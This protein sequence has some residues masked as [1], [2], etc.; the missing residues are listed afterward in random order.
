MLH[1]SDSIW[2]QAPGCNRCS[3]Q[4]EKTAEAR[5]VVDIIFMFIAG[6][7]KDSKMIDWE[8][9]LLID[10]LETNKKWREAKEIMLQMWEEDPN[11]VKVCTRLAFLCWYTLQSGVY[12]GKTKL[13]YQVMMNA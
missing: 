2:H 8:W 10:E 1:K 4:A 9:A 12:H 3:E 7:R 11:N 6:K 5:L 13:I